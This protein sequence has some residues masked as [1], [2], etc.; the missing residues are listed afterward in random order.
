MS[1][2][3]FF[4]SDGEYYRAAYRDIL[5]MDNVRF[6][7][8]YL[9]SS[10]KVLKILH[11]LHC[12]RGLAK[13]VKLPLRSIWYKFYCPEDPVPGA[14]Y[15]FI[16]FYRWNTICENGFLDYL[17]KR[18]PGCKCI[19]YLQ[20]IDA[21]RKINIDQ[22]KKIF[23]H[24]MIFEKNF[25]KEHGI[26]YYPLVYSKDADGAEPFERTIDLLFVGK[27][28][29]RYETLQS[30]YDRLTKEGINCQFYL[31][32]MDQEVEDPRSG[33]HIL[34]IVPYEKNIS[35]LK[36]SKCILDIVP[37]GTNCNTLR[38]NEAICYGN[39]ILTNNKFILE[40]KYYNAQFI[41][42][43]QAF[44]DID[45][46]FL[47]QPYETVEYHYIEKL[48]PKTLLRHLEKVLNGN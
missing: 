48:S 6:Q 30:I 33:I 14:T 36:K 20:D 32:K 46:A 45:I 3:I 5:D 31:S 23:D 19:L 2:Y 35:L 1:R 47:K 17:R 43:Y 13:Y 12:F 39:R 27:A 34:D 18:Y 42:V 38:V 4:A 21:A 24:V 28:K 16:F 40:E 7:V 29:G 37:K 15:F 41:S 11:S 10:S 44:N 22:S 8:D 9:S 26:E 25:A